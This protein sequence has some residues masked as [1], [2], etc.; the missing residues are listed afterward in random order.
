MESTRSAEASQSGQARQ[1]TPGRS[2]LETLFQSDS[3]AQA[4]WKIWTAR[5]P[6]M[7]ERAC[8]SSERRRRRSQ[9]LPEKLKGS[10]RQILA[11]EPNKQTSKQL[12][13]SHTTRKV[14]HA[15]ES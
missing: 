8:S 5:R 13:V 11:I 1:R 9:T 12:G 14:R 2:E 15:R 7:A 6:S 3:L 10:S 4:R